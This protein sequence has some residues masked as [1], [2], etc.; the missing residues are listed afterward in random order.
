MHQACSL[1][2][3]WGILHVHVWEWFRNNWQLLHCGNPVKVAPHLVFQS[4]SVSFG[5][6]YTVGTL[7]GA[8]SHCSLSINMQM[9]HGFIIFDATNELPWNMN[10]PIS[11]LHIEPHWWL[12]PTPYKKWERL[13]LATQHVKVIRYSKNSPP[14]MFPSGAQL[15]G[16][17]Q[18]L[19]Y[20]H[21]CNVRG[22][23]LCGLQHKCS[24]T[25]NL[26]APTTLLDYEI[27]LYKYWPAMCKSCYLFYSLSKLAVDCKSI[28]S[29][30]SSGGRPRSL[31]YWVNNLQ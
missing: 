31:A 11:I 30:Y 19:I 28:H 2:V 20:S 25:L 18:S 14:Y 12:H 15:L 13:L 4:G 27:W 8:I 5:T 7:L 24:V 3:T 29:S 1:C 10:M 22:V 26:F 6:C 9:P 16:H 17:L 21:R 23:I